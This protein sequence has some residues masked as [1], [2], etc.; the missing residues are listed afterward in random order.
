MKRIDVINKKAFRLSRKRYMT[1]YL[2][3]AV[4]ILILSMASCS[5]N[6]P[7]STENTSGKLI[8]Q[9]SNTAEFSWEL[10]VA[11]NIAAQFISIN[12]VGGYPFTFRYWNNQI[13]YG[14]IDCSDP[15]TAPYGCMIGD[16]PTVCAHYQGINRVYGP[17]GSSYLY[18]TRNGNPIFICSGTYTD[19]PGEILVVKMDG[20][21]KTGAAFGVD[22]QNDIFGAQ[23]PRA[24]DFTVLSKHLNGI[25]FVWPASPGNE[26]TALIDWK[27]PGS[28]QQAGDRLF[29]PVEKSCNYEPEN[30]KCG[31]G[32]E[33]RGAILVLKLAD[34]S[35][36]TVAPDNPAVDCQIDFHW[37]PEIN[38]F[39]ALPTIGTLAVTKHGGNYLF[40]HTTGGSY[41]KETALT[42]YKVEENSLCDFF[43][44]AERPEFALPIIYKI[45]DWNADLTL[46]DDAE[47][48]GEDGWREDQSCAGCDFDW[49]MIN[50]IYDNNDDLYLIATDKSNV[51]SIDVR[52]DFARLYKII[53]D[54]FNNRY[55]VKYIA[56]KH[57][58]L[59]NTYFYGSDY[60]FDMG[61][62]DAV[63]GAYVTPEGRLILYSG[64]HDNDLSEF[65]YA[66]GASC[67][68]SEL[69][70]G[71]GLG[72]FAS[73]FFHPPVITEH[74]TQTTNEGSNTVF[75]LGSFSDSVTDSQT[76]EATVNWGDG[77]ESTFT[78]V[79]GDLPSLEHQ[80]QDGPATYTVNIVIADSDGYKGHS[81]FQ[82]VVNNI[83]P[84]V[85]I[86]SINNNSPY[87]LVGNI[88]V[89]NGSFTDPGTMDTHEA[90][91]DWGEG[92]GF[93]PIDI[94]TSVNTITGEHMYS[95]TNIY[96]VTLQ[97][98]DKDGAE[99]SDIATIT[100][101]TPEDGL[102]MICNDLDAI[103]GNA[104]VKP[105]VARHIN[106]AINNLC[107]NNDGMAE[108]GAV[109]KLENTNYVPGLVKL[110]LA[111]KELILAE[112]E[113]T[114]LD[115][116]PYTSFIK[117]VA[118]TICEV[119]EQCEEWN[120]IS[121]I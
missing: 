43:P 11:P 86:D 35:D 85:S 66:P 105:D 111:L 72:E 80:Y 58:Y 5:S 21:N 77:Y 53:Y 99:N 108:N 39:K 112:A 51:S 55:N 30:E 33:H 16:D 96:T 95:S 34:D 54:D 74:D 76:W 97:V 14:G 110:E 98:V 116:S 104:G 107:S 83:A 118:K 19:Y 106:K 48:L 15:E 1:C 56:E 93:E 47:H 32:E 117:L 84:Q 9:L 92:G 12:G 52:H 63:G 64:A 41:E 121:G 69:C 23:Q 120:K 29:I 17:D 109:S 8:T 59:G 45:H 22:P 3:S 6:N 20:R 28:G 81:S 62:L 73:S 78:T 87:T 49:Q 26:L 114:S 40:A 37:D 91:V 90:M 100:V 25:D 18:L 57:L 42:F 13:S 115:L 71:L 10:P 27:H 67:I 36:S 94:N 79:P 61:S 119:D 88:I 70:K 82:V 50:F 113:D 102:L 44:V 38:N 103:A 60:S 46:S 31:G 75:E 24:N 89:L 2:F 65:I 68:D 4:V 7:V 101:T